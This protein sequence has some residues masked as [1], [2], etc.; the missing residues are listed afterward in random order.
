MK[1]KINKIVS[2]ILAFCIIVSLVTVTGISANAATTDKDVSNGIIS[3]DF[4]Y[5]IHN[6]YAKIVEYEGSNT[7]LV[8]PS[9]IHGYIVKYVGDN[10]DIYENF[11]ITETPI[12]SVTIPNTVTEI[13]INAF[14]NC[15]YLTTVNIPDS[16]TTIDENAFRDCKSLTS[17]NIPDSVTTI[18]RFVF[19]GTGIKT[20]VLNKNVV[21]WGSVAFE[22]VK[23]IYV[24]KGI[25]KGFSDAFDLKDSFAG[26]CDIYFEGNEE[27]WKLIESYNVKYASPWIRIHY[28]HPVDKP[29]GVSKVVSDDFILNLTQEKGNVQSGEMVLQPGTY[30]FNIQKG[31]IF[32][33]LD[34]KNIFGY[35]KTIN[36]STSGS[37]TCKPSYKTKTTLVATGGTYSFA[38][39]TETNALSVKRTGDIPEVYLTGVASES[40]SLHLPLEP[41]NGTNLSVKTVYLP[42]NSYRYKVIKNGTELMTTEKNLIMP[43]NISPPR[44]LVPNGPYLIGVGASNCM[45]TFIFNHDTNEI[46]VKE[47]IDNKESFRDG[48]IYVTGGDFNFHLNDNKGESDIATGTITLKKGAYSFKVY[49]RGVPCGS[50]SIYYNAGTRT[51]NPNF[52]LPSVLYASGGKYKFTFEKSTGRL[53][54][55]RA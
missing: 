34:G 44:K 51:L 52:M 17:I 33:V 48:G 9:T 54:I 15:E 49:N 41:I 28:N 32:N 1:R 46:S 20:W 21:N 45:A 22:P 53:F 50:N 26:F 47:I 27:E 14:R 23:Y 3:G 37:L 19:R 11:P 8:I 39:N 5:V 16:V 2:L 40:N 29:A 30:Q 43:P 36:D 42:S 4:V 7:E 10:D 6:G 38:F 31:D 18:G 24:P 12:T 55:H 35:N 25:T 13:G